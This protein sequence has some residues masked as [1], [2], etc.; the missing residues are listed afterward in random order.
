MEIGQILNCNYKPKVIFEKLKIPYLPKEQ[1]TKYFDDYKNE[2]SA[3][4]V[5]KKL[6]EIYEKKI[7]NILNKI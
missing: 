1:Q 7:T 4:K 3:I 2:E 6:I 5:N